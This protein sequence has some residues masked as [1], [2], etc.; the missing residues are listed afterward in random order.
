ME[1]L[2]TIAYKS[3]ITRVKMDEDSLQRRIYFITFVESIEMIFSQY[4]ENC[5]VLL[6]HPKIGGEILKML[7]KRPLGIFFM[8][9]LMYTAGD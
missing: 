4:I 5:K 3:N 8:Q 9:I 7:Q 6:D 2:L 1:K